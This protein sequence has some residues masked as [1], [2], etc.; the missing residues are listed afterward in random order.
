MAGQSINEKTLVEKSGEL[1][2]PIEGILDFHFHINQPNKKCFEALKASCGLLLF[3][4]IHSIP[5]SHKFFQ[6]LLSEF[7]RYV[8]SR[9]NF[10]IPGK[11]QFQ[12]YLGVTGSFKFATQLS[13]LPERY[14]Y[15]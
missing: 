10:H 15:C 7:Y 3:E 8:I 12:S 11:G 1:R 4:C 2:T 5:L 9:P 6:V 13:I 14:I